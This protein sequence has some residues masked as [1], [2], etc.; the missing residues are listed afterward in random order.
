MTTLPTALPTAARAAVLALALLAAACSHSP[1]TPADNA[2][3][4]GLTPAEV[5]LIGE[6]H[7]AP[8][9][10]RLQREAAAALA[11]HGRLAALVMEMAEAGRSTSRLPRGASEADVREALAWNDAAWPWASYGPVAMEAVRAGVPVLGGNLPRAQMREAMRDTA[12][13]ARVPPAV[14]RRQI[15][16][17][18]EGHCGLLP[19]SQWPG[20]ARIQIARDASLAQ[21][22]AGARRPGQTVLLVAG[23]GHVRRD[24]GI[25]LHWEHDLRAKVVIAQARQEGPPLPAAAADRI[26]QTPAVPPKDHCAGLRQHSGTAR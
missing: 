20:M 10:Q 3:W 15:A 4:D 8:D 16:A 19:A 12:W 1:R 25:P 22:A 14:L 18:E 7:D 5:L 13:D 26:V 17:M 9:H 21:T 6:Q 2:P 23:A 11:S 24:L